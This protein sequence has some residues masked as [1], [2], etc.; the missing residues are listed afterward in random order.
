MDKHI[1][2]ANRMKTRTP[3]ITDKAILHNRLSKL[4][5]HLN[6]NQEK[7]IN[8]VAAFLKIGKWYMTVAKNVGIVYYENGYWKGC[9]RLT[10]QR[11]NKFMDECKN[12]SKRTIR[13]SKKF[14]QC[15]IEFPKMKEAKVMQKSK[16]VQK[17][18][19]IKRIKFLFTGKI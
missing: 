6:N 19:L 8:D 9:Q 7:S 5:H 15:S 12:Y 18:T 13:K 16:P 10:D 1:T 14:D 2:I 17:P 4:C 3:M 11:L